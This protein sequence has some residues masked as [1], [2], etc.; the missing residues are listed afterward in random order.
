MKSFSY[1]ELDMLAG[2]V[3]PERAVL[4]TL[5]VGGGDEN[6]N[7]NVN[8]LGGGEGDDSTVV[9]SCS[10]NSNQPATGLL[11]IINGVPAANSQICTPAA[12]A[13]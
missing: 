10:A 1:T 13:G 9:S 5:L 8:H 7:A 12:V 2:E 6:E 4:S 11:T 3:L